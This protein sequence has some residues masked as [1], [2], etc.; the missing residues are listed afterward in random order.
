M[1]RLPRLA[2]AGRPHYVLQR[3]H[4]GSPIFVDAEDR[5]AYLQILKEAIAANGIALHAYAL[6]DAEVRLLVTPAQ[7]EGVSRL[8]QAV[9]RRYV[10]GFNRRHGRHGTLWSG[11]FKSTVVDDAHVIDCVRHIETLPSGP[12]GSQWSS[13]GHHIGAASSPLIREHPSYWSIG[14][15]PFDREAQY[16]RLLDEP[17]DEA[18]SAA[19]DAA[20][21]KGWPLGS[22]EF[23]HQLASETARRLHPLRRGRPSS[24]SP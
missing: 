7:A 24:R 14:N 18:L 12:V 9:G 10:A 1:A 13:A 16:R 8:M 5:Q 3:G 22:A 20:I 4:N 23:T 6:G 19:I 2:L 17:L 11:R 15:T 21:D